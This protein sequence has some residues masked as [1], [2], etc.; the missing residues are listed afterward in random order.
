MRRVM[1]SVFAILAALT[2]AQAQSFPSKPVTVVI[3]LAAGG[4]V[5]TMVRTMLESMRATLGQPIL[6]ENIGG[7][8]GT[9]GVNRVARAAPD[10]YTI[11][12]GTWG[13]HV[14]NAFVYTT[15]Y[16]LL[17]DLDAVA[18]LPSV[19]HW[20]I[21]RK[22]LP[23]ANLKELI[24]YM[25]ADAGKVTAASVGAG[26]S[27]AV[28]SYYLGK[29][30]GTTTTLVPYRGGA[31]AL[32][33]IV[34]GNVDTMCDLAANSLGQVKAGTIKA[35]AVASKKRWFAMPDGRRGR[36]SGRRSH[37]L[38]RRLCAE[39]HAER[40]RRQ[41][42]CGFQHR[43]G[44]SGRPSAHRRPGPGDSPARAADARSVRHLSESRD[45]QMGRGDPRIRHQGAM[46]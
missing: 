22:N 42:Q 10:G 32:Q 33:D 43:D 38:A 18:L 14:V 28:C 24:A 31:P 45:G 9:T 30:T 11:S 16:D 2:G 13:T 20:F 6:V 17:K 15:P 27:S 1:L 29:V 23:P 7:A 46:S 3:P 34:A 41:A 40:H 39:G 8:G 12:V 19:P 21:A 35:Y 26:G 36:R 44:R 5:D 37:Q 25:K 4:A